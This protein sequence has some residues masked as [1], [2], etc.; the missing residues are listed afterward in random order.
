MKDRKVYID[1][2]RVFACISVIIIHVFTTALTDF[3]NHS[4]NEKIIAKVIINLLHFA[5]PIFFMITG[6]LFLSSEKKYD[7]SSFFKKYV[8]KY[9]VA[10]LT[11][12]YAYAIIEEIFYKNLS[13]SMPFVAFYNT[14]QGKTWEHMWY[15]YSLVGIM[16][17][18]PLLKILKEKD[19]KYLKYLLGILLISS[20]VIPILTNLFNFTIGI[21]LIVFSPYLA[22]AIIGYFLGK[23]ENKKHNINL[24]ISVIAISLSQILPIVIH[25]DV[26]DKLIVFGNYDSPFILMLSISIFNL[27]KKIKAENIIIK[28]I[29]KYSYGIYLIHMFWINL[30]YKF[31]KF[32]IFGQ[33][34]IIK[35]LLVFILVL[36]LSCLSTFLF[37]K[38]HYIKNII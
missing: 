23:T 2:L 26:T 17:L 29:S 24:F 30:I 6:Y 32:N 35:S 19:E 18:I 33:F 11:F 8:L 20:I 16:L 1:W 28:S 14:I 38:I 15:L 31:F 21:D 12:G 3:P 5:V 22:Y 13:L 7:L 10:I 34:Y 36:L 37:K 9:I 25:N 27:F 4:I